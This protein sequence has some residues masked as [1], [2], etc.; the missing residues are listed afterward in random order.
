[1]WHWLLQWGHRL[2]AM[3]T[4]SD[5]R[6]GRDSPPRFNGATAFQRWKHA[7]TAGAAEIVLHAS[8]GPPPFSDGNA[9]T[10]VSRQPSPGTFNG[11]TAFQRWKPGNEPGEGHPRG[12]FN[13]ATAFQRWK[14]VSALCSMS[15]PYS[16]QWGHRLSAMETRHNPGGYRLRRLPFNGATAFQRWEPHR[17]LGKIEHRRAPSMGPPSFSDGNIFSQ[18]PGAVGFPV[19]GRLQWGHRLS[20]METRRGPDDRGPGRHPSMGPPPFSDG[21]LAGDGISRRFHNPSMGPPP[22]SD[23]NELHLAAGHLRREPSMGPP[24]FSDGNTRCPS[25]PWPTWPPFNGA[26]AFQRW[27]L[28]PNLAHRVSDGVPSMGPPPFSD[29]NRTS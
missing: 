16:L 28:A 12:A 18:G 11:A 1:M 15:T 6:R 9:E 24:P 25:L 20:A 21:N 4:C 10:P 22:F 26:T 5:R 3:E 7:P 14:R 8:M 17:V 19:G 2:S 27:K 29:G 13:G 23:G